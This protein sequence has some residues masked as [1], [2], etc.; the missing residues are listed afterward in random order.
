M[1]KL[2][3]I[4]NEKFFEF[5]NKVAE[6]YNEKKRKK[7]EFKKVYDQFQAELAELDEEAKK[8]QVDFEEWKSNLEA[9]SES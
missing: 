4:L 9:T 8:A 3:H 7:E 6:I 2:E 5:S 1:E